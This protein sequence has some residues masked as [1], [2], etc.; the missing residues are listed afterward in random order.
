MIDKGSSSESKTGCGVTTRRVERCCSCQKCF[1]PGHNPTVLACGHTVGSSCLADSKENSDGS[2]PRCKYFRPSVSATAAA[3]TSHAAEQEL[4]PLFQDV[5]GIIPSTHPVEWGGDYNVMLHPSAYE[6]EVERAKA[7]SQQDLM[8]PHPFHHEPLWEEMQ[9]AT[10]EVWI[11]YLPDH[12]L[13]WPGLAL[14]LRMSNWDNLFSRF[15]ALVNRV[16]GAGFDSRVQPIVEP[17]PCMMK[18]EAAIQEFQPR[19]TL[20]EHRKWASTISLGFVQEHVFQRPRE[21]DQL[22]AQHGRRKMAWLQE[23]CKQIKVPM[24]LERPFTRRLA[25]RGWFSNALP[26]AIPPS[27]SKPVMERSEARHV[28]FEFEMSDA[29]N[30]IGGVDR[31]HGHSINQP[32]YENIQTSTMYNT[33]VHTSQDD[34]GLNPT[35]TT[36]STAVRPS[37]WAQAAQLPLVARPCR[38]GTKC[39]NPDCKFNHD[40]GSPMSMDIEISRTDPPLRINRPCRYSSD[41]KR[42]DCPFIHDIELISPQRMD[43]S[44]GTDSATTGPHRGRSRSPT[45]EPSKRVQDCRFGSNC[46]NQETCLFSHGRANDPNSQRQRQSGNQHQSGNKLQQV[47]KFN[48]TCLRPDCNFAHSGPA[49]GPDTQLRVEHACKFGR[50]CTNNKCEKSHPSPAAQTGIDIGNDAAKQKQERDNGEGSANGQSGRIGDGNKGGN[51]G[52]NK[53]SKGRWNKDAALKKQPR[54]RDGSRSR[55]SQKQEQGNKDGNAPNQAVGF[56]NMNEEL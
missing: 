6:A 52:G 49:S 27:P 48:E 3:S 33:N 29:D 15:C 21:L 53:V 36:H 35:H 39:H 47:C 20:A 50:R 34:I 5:K 7:L 11:I 43:L 16:R 38:F 24:F 28:A 2:C 9:D 51:R 54:R 31:Y 45:P 17:L 19:Y 44:G 4:R 26:I 37:Y 8:A 12:V 18:V 13:R 1:G 40:V 41:C 56:S 22:Q 32:H 23:V 30:D 25:Q 42:P 46:R 55:G 14:Y 10:L